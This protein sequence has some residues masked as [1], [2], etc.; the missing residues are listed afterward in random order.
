MI[1]D[2]REKVNA[3]TREYRSDLFIAAVIFL[4]GLGSFGLGRLSVV[5]PEKPPLAVTGA[6]IAAGVAPEGIAGAAGPAGDMPQRNATS[7]AG[8]YMGSKSG[9]VYHL[10]W[11]PGALRIKEQNKVWFQNKEEAEQ[12]G[13]KPAA[14]CPGL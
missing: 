6:D 9:A 11:C 14:N 10:P 4:V 2:Y 5:M 12:K 1:G 3:W 13:Y 7:A 8:R